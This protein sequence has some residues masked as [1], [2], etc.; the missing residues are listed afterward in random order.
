MNYN[1]AKRIPIRSEG[2]KIFYL[3]PLPVFVVC[4]YHSLILIRIRDNRVNFQSIMF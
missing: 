1:Q 2:Q 3:N 4:E